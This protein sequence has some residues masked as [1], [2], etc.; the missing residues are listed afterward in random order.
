[1]KRGMKIA[2]LCIAAATVLLLVTWGVHWMLW[3][4]GNYP[5]D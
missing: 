5:I 2:L 1:M 3:I 4:G